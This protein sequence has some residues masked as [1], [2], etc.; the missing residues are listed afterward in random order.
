MK[1]S[2]A[3]RG[4]NLPAFAIMLA[5]LLSTVAGY[6]APFSLLGPGV[7]T[8]DFRV[9]TFATNLNYP[10]GMA[11]LADGSLLVAVSDGTDFFSSPGRLIR[12]VDT[13]Q[14]GIADGTG[15]VLYSGLPSGQ[16]SLRRGGNLVFVTGQGSG[17]PIIVL[18]TGETPG[19]VLSLV[20]QINVNYPVSWYHPHS[21]L[22]AHDIPGTTNSFYLFFQLGSQFNFDPTTHSASISS[23]NIPGATG[24]ILGDSIYRLTITDHTNSVTASNLTQIASGLRNPA[25]F[26]FHPQSGDFYFEDNGIDGLVNPNEPLSADELNVIPAAELG[27]VPVKFFGFPTNYI[28]YRTGRNIGGLG[29]QPLVAFQPLPNPTTGSESEGPND[30][31]FAPPRFPNGLNNGIFVGFH[32]KFNA[33]GIANEENPLVYVDLTTT[34]YFHFIGNAEPN[35]G[36]LDGLVSTEDSL[37]IADLS[38]NGSLSS[39]GGRGVIY[40]IKSLVLPPVELRW[41]GQRVELT[42]T[43]GILQHAA[44]VTGPWN[45]VQGATSPHLVDTDQ[46]QKFFRTRN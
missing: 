7:R 23:A 9:T 17:K 18:R 19:A 16:T 11:R 25:G 30:I 35:V 28:E 24:T 1:N 45:D 4:G 44:D 13:N 38:S 34:N 2:T 43:Y 39:G 22:L 10:L 40:Q 5:L 37:F 21:A 32:G 46:S 27:L 8:N 15:G 36:H 14:D 31:V 20:G 26:A 3:P 12:L 41:L 29:F 42:W 6:S 33:G